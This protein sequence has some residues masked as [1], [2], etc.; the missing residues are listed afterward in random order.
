[1]ESWAL[2]VGSELECAQ[3][4]A[5]VVMLVARGRVTRHAMHATYPTFESILARM[6]RPGWII[7]TSELTDFEASAVG[8][9]TEYFKLFKEHGGEKVI[10]VSGLGTARM[11]ATT[12]SFAARVPLEACET[13]AEACERLGVTHPPARALLHR[14]EPGTSVSGTRAKITQK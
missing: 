7:D 12:I 3:I 2:N 5:Q 1:M 6:R 14:R 13:F 9:G 8:I 11:A 10:F 4:A